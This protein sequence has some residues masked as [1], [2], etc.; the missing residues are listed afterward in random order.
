MEKEVYS[1]SELLEITMLYPY[2]IEQ[3]MKECKSAAVAGQ[4]YCILCNRLISM[5]IIKELL[6]LGYD[7]SEI[8]DFVG[9]GNIKV[10]W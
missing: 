7:V 4:N 5:D 10:S 9:N 2:K 3:I 1:A 6:R 8:K